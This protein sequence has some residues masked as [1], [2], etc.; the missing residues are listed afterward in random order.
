MFI[1]ASVFGSHS[2]ILASSALILIGSWQRSS[3]SSFVWLID[4]TYTSH[5]HDLW[6]KGENVIGAM[7]HLSEG[8]ASRISHYWDM[9]DVAA[10]QWE[11][12]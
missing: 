7:G 11:R 3:Y 4:K 6:W 12:W 1:T 8:A 10:E 9:L 5:T 2:G